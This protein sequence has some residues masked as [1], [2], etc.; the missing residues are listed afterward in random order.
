MCSVSVYGYRARIGD[1]PPPVVTEVFPYEFYRIVPDGV[2]LGVTT[3]A[4]LDVTAEETSP[5][6]MQ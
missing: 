3:L 1:T 4:I 6:G 2:T 5:R